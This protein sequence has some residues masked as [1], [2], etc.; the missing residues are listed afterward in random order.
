MG[1]GKMEGKEE[2]KNLTGREHLPFDKH[3]AG[4]AAETLSKERILGGICN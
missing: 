4:H 2:K 3:S 1:G